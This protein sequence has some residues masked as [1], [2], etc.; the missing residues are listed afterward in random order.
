MK[1][2]K[3]SRIPTDTAVQIRVLDRD[4]LT[5]SEIA[6]EMNLPYDD[7]RLVLQ[8]TLGLREFGAQVCWI[9]WREVRRR[10]DQFEVELAMGKWDWFCKE[11][12]SLMRMKNARAA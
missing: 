10:R 5:A 9:G 11:W 3:P 4:G 8:G 7:V 12:D 1:P 6:K 2:G